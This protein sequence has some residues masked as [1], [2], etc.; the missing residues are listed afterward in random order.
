VQALEIGLS[1][2]AYASEIPIMLYNDPKR[3]FFQGHI[4]FLFGRRK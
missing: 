3:L 2:D 4:A 1:V